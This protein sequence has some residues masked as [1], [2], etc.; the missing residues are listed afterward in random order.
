MSALYDAKVALKGMLDAYTWPTR[1]PLI[2]WGGPTKPE[3]W[4]KYAGAW[5][6]L[7]EIIYFGQATI[8]VP[9]ESLRLGR[10]A[11]REEFT[12]PVVIE[13]I[14]EGDDEVAV[15]ARADELYHSVVGVISSDPTIGGSVISIGGFTSNRATE[16]GDDR[17]RCQVTVEQSCVGFTNALA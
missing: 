1:K 10:T 16:P 17:W 9:A 11:W 5:G 4:P 3:D 14:Q 2:L 15:E 12:L 7:W 6:G 13:V 8:N